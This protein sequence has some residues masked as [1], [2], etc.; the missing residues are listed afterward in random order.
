MPMA[1]RPSAC[2]AVQSVKGALGPATHTKRLRTQTIVE[3]SLMSTTL[4]PQTEK[5]HV[6]SGLRIFGR[7]PGEPLPSPP[8]PAG[9]RRYERLLAWTSSAVAL[10]AILIAITFA[11]KAARLE[12]QLGKL[13]R[14]KSS[15][16]DSLVLARQYDSLSAEILDLQQ[17]LHARQV[18][19]IPPELHPIP[20]PNFGGTGPLV[21][22]RPVPSYFR[23]APPPEEQ[24]AAARALARLDARASHGSLRGIYEQDD[25]VSSGALQGLTHRGYTFTSRLPQKRGATN[26]IVL[27]T[28]VPVT[29]AV[30]VAYQL[31][32]SGIPVKRI[33]IGS[34]T[35]RRNNIELLYSRQIV[36]WPELTVADLQRFAAGA[37][38]R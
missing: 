19:A 29:D 12:E 6:L 22:A 1:V 26:A 18:G 37:G 31:I 21:G 7:T 14:Q 28:D 5:P 16:G 33:R 25:I 13:R 2:F 30:A 32:A 9:R 17:E 27:G 3:A 8:S 20:V 36:D 24:R 38:P 15:M 23:L 11:S 34:E 35:S 4:E 10:I